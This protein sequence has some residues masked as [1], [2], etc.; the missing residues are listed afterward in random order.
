MQVQDEAPLDV[1]DLIERT[2]RQM[3]AITGL[4][5]ETVS[6][7]DRGDEG[8]NVAIDMLEHR[9]IPRTQDLLASFEVL[10]DPRGTLRRWKRTGRFVRGQPG[11]A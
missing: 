9:A 2:K 1:P 8:W 6:R 11:E 10:V 7:F 5:P 4:M 3:A